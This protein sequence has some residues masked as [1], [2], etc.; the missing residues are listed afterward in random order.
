MLPIMQAYLGFSSDM[1][2]F[3]AALY[4]LFD[5][6]ITACNVAGNGAMA[7]IFDRI[8]RLNLKKQ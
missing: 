1:L 7:L 2:A 6:I 5:P 4:V 3:I 8:S